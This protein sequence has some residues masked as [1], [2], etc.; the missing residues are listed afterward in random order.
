MMVTKEQVDK[1]FDA[2]RAAYAAYYDAAKAAE[3]N[4]K[5]AAELNAKAAARA[6]DEAWKKY[7]KLWRE[8]EN[9]NKSN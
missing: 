8:F 9:E 1:A 3:L 7:L 2:Y 4:A 6:V 5:A